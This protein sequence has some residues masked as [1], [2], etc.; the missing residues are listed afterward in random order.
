VGL[1]RPCL[2]RWRGGHPQALQH[3]LIPIVR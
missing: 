2:A 3:V 1:H